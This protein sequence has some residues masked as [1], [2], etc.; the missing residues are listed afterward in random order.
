MIPFAETPPEST[1]Q[2]LDPVTMLV[3]IGVALFLV[4]LTNLLLRQRGRHTR[5]SYLARAMVG[6]PEI[7]QIQSADS[8]G[9]I[10]EMV[11]FAA[12]LIR[13]VD[14]ET[15]LKAVLR[16]EADMSTGLVHGIAAPHARLHQLNRSIVLFGRSARGIDWD[17][18]DDQPAHLIFLILSPEDDAQ[19]QLHMLAE[20]GHCADDDD[21]L[22]LL[23]TAKDCR[24]ITKAIEHK[25]SG[26]KKK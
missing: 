10:G 15:L 26:R 16:R 11:R 25:T 20:I 22:E 7:M 24:T 14:E 17:C 13:T 1:L 18:L 9:A 8:A 21:C 19:E 2:T 12:R 3:G 4:V 5:S 23:R 6:V